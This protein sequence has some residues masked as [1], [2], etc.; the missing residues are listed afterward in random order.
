MIV[1][2]YTNFFPAPHA[3]SIIADQWCKEGG[4]RTNGRVKIT[5][6]PGA[7]LTPANQTY[8]SVV[9]GIADIGLSVQAYTRGKFPLTEVIDLPLAYNSGYV[10][11]KMV[12][13]VY[14]K[15]QPKEYDETQVMYL[16]A[17][18]PGI[19]HTKKP[20]YKLEDLKGLKIRSTGLSA[21]VVQST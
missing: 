21:K 18:G 19:L 6:F 17:H 3:N 12:N 14:K 9:K 13:E 1:L 10:A 2:K 4:E 8:D 5:Y 11:T 7:T 20:V 16:H 15:F